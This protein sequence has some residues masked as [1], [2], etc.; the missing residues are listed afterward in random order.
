MAPGMNAVQTMRQLVERDWKGVFAS[1]CSHKN[2]V[3]FALDYIC[4]DQSPRTI[5]AVLASSGRQNDNWSPFYEL[6]SRCDWDTDEIFRPV[7]NSALTY[8]PDDRWIPCILDDTGLGRTG[9]KI[10]CA[11]WMRDPMSPPF[12]PNLMYGLRFVQCSILLQHD[13]FRE[14]GP[15]AYPVRFTSAPV[16]KKPGKK[17]S[18]DERR[19]YREEKKNR[20]L[21]RYGVQAIGSVRHE[22]DRTSFAHRKL[23]VATDGSYCNRTVFTADLVNTAIIARARK[24]TRLCLRAPRGTSRYYSQDKFTPEQARQDPNVPWRKCRVY[25]DGKYRLVRYKRIDHVLWQSGAKKKPL[26]LFVIAPVPYR[27]SPRGK[28]NY[29]DPAYLLCT[30]PSVG[31]VMAIRTY[32][33]RNEIEVNHR[34]E[35]SLMHVE[36]AQVWNPSSVHRYP[37]FAVAC[38][39]IML[40]TSLICFGP[41]RTKDYPP[42]PKWRNRISKRP[43]CRDI[44]KLFQAHHNATQRDAWVQTPHRLNRSIL[45][46]VTTAA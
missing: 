4:C 16:V 44:I 33:A 41:T 34:D 28:L 29:R 9:K 6:F 40:M 10:P 20:N 38:Y 15:R 19:S 18:Q 45:R 43:S 39:S 23:L 24:N 2:A 17:A 30:D 25:L 22:C 26:T 5:A 8:L 36:D 46:Q 37:T 1:K 12:R 3:D 31:S 27:Q 11:Q 13:R 35:K 32:F 7:L 42:S 14:T 21:S